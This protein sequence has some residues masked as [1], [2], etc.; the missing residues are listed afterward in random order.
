MV[1]TRLRLPT[2]ATEN[3]TG[4]Y[5]LS[6]YVQ[7][8]SYGWFFTLLTFAIAIIV[9]IALK[10]YD[11][12]K[13]FATAAFFNMIFMILFRTIGFVGNTFMYL[14]IVFVGVGIVWLK[15]NNSSRF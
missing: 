12:P 1:V 7:E 13:A 14:S 9:F 8:V 10:D 4:L 2:N 11:T 15:L 6:Q 3:I 5:S